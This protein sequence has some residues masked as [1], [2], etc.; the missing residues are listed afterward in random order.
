MDLSDFR[1]GP[2]RLSRASSWSSR[3]TATADLPCCVKVPLVACHRHYPGGTVAALLAGCP[4][5]A[6]PMPMVGRLPRLTFSGPARRSL[7]LWPADS[8]SCPRQPFGVEGSRLFVASQSTSTASRW[9]TS[10]PG[11]SSHPLELSH[12]CTAHTGCVSCRVICCTRQ[13]IARTRQLTQPVRQDSCTRQL[14]QPVRQVLWRTRRHDTEL[15][16]P[17]REPASMSWQ[18]RSLKAPF[19]SSGPSGSGRA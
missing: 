19:C 15:I 16:R 13:L 7:A 1:C 8:L 3:T 14:T 10:L 6:F 2:V 9:S 18:M 5:V 11:W 17:A 12:L 4:S